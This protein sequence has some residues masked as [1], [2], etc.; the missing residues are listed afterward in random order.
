MKT[1]ILFLAAASAFA[2]T[3]LYLSYGGAGSSLRITG[4]TNATPIVCSTPAVHGFSTGNKVY[5][6]G[7]RGNRAAN[8]PSGSYYTVT[9]SPGS[10]TFSLQNP[11]SSPVAGTGAYDGNGFVTLV[12]ATTLVAHPRGLLDGPGGTITTRALDPD[13]TG[14]LKAPSAVTGFV[15]WD[16]ISTYNSS[17][18]ASPLSAASLAAVDTTEPMLPIGLAWYSNQQDTARR[19]AVLAW[20]NNIGSVVDARN[21]TECFFACCDETKVGCGVDDPEQDWRWFFRLG[22]M[23]TYNFTRSLM[24]TPERQAFADKMLNGVGGEAKVNRLTFGGTSRVTASG[25]ALTCVSGACNFTSIASPTNRKIYIRTTGGVYG[26]WNKIASV[27]DDN[28]IVLVSAVPSSVSAESNIPWAYVKDWDNTMYGDM[29]MSSH[30]AY[31]PTFLTHEAYSK[32]VGAIDAS[33]TTFS[34]QNCGNFPLAEVARDYYTKMNSEWMKLTDCT[35]GSPG[36]ATVERGALFSTAATHATLQAMWGTA[37]PQF[38][39]SHQAVPSST[40]NPW[41]LDLEAPSQNLYWSK[42]Y[43]TIK[44]ACA[45]ADDDERAR[46]L[47]QDGWNYFYNFVYPDAKDRWTG[48][49]QGGFSYGQPRWVTWMSEIAF[50]GKY[51]F[52]PAIDITDGEWLKATGNYMPHL[53][54]PWSTSGSMIWGDSG[55]DP[56]MFARFFRYLMIQ[57]RLFDAATE[58]SQGMFWFRE[59]FDKWTSA[60]MKGPADFQLMAPAYLYIPAD[61]TC[62]SAGCVDHRTTANL[63]RF[64]TT[65]DFDFT[66]YPTSFGFVSS[67]SDWTTAPLSWLTMFA[68]GNPNDHTGTQAPGTYKI[69]VAGQFL[70]ANGPNTLDNGYGANRPEGLIVIANVAGTTNVG[71][72]TVTGPADAI[73]DLA[74]TGNYIVTCTA[75]AA[76]GGTFSVAAPNGVVLG[77]AT[78]GV[79]F[80]AP[81]YYGPLKF[82]INDGSIDWAVGDKKMVQVLGM[83]QRFSRNS[84]P[85]INKAG[86][87][88]FTHGVA[89]PEQN[90]N[91]LGYFGNFVKVDQTKADSGYAFWRV[92]LDNSYQTS[93]A[94]TRAR[95]HFAH[96]T[97]TEAYTIVYDELATSSAKPKE[98]SAFCYT[99]DGI[100]TYSKSGN[101]LNCTRSAS[102]LQT[103][104]LLPTDTSKITQTGGQVMSSYPITYSSSSSSQRPNGVLR[105]WT[106]VN[107]V[108]WPIR[109]RIDDDGPGGGSTFVT[110]TWGLVGVDTGRQWYFNPGTAV[111]TQCD[112][113]TANTCPGAQEAA[114]PTNSYVS[115]DINTDRSAGWTI[116]DGSTLNSEF[117][118]VHCAFAGTTGD[119]PPTSTLTT[120]SSNSR[121]V[122]INHAARPRVF[123][124]DNDS[125]A[126]NVSVTF[127]LSGLSAAADAL[128]SGL[129][130]GTW[131]ILKDAVEIYGDVVVGADGTAHIP[132]AGGHG[133]GAY[134]F[135]KTGETVAIDI[136]TASPLPDGTVGTPYSET[137]TAS[138]GTGPYTW[139]RIGG[140]SFPSGLS[141]SA[142]GELTGTPDTA[143]QASVQVQA[144]DVTP[145]CTNKFLSITIQAAGTPLAWSTP[146]TF[147]D[148]Q[149]G[150]VYTTQTLVCTGG[151][152]PY[153][154]TLLSGT[155][156]GGLTQSGTGGNTVSGTLDS[157]SNGNYSP[158]FRCTDS[159]EPPA[160]ADRTFTF[161]I[162]PAASNELTLTSPT[163]PIVCVSESFCSAQWTATGGTSPLTWSIPSGTLPT[164]MAQQLDGSINGTPSIDGPDQDFP[165][166]VRVTGAT[167]GT[168]EDESDV[169]FSITRTSFSGGCT[170][171]SRA[172]DVG[173]TFRIRCSSLDAN[174]PV[175]VAVKSGDTVID[176]VTLT[177]GGAV[178]EGGLNGLTAA[179]SY[180]IDW[181]YLSQFRRDIVAT[182]ST[183]GGTANPKL[184][185]HPPQAGISRVRAK[186]GL[187]SVA[188]N[189]TSSQACSTGCA[190]TLPSLT[191]GSVYLYQVEWL[192]GSDVPVGPALAEAKLLIE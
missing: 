116:N 77:N 60:T 113:G 155:L 186:Y 62:P 161:D 7:V 150:T 31:L 129:D 57:Y 135:V 61:H 58:V 52:S 168:D 185:R 23:E 33:Q 181:N 8:T 98:R 178:R 100:V 167:G 131:D 5:I 158:A 166:R 188:E 170:F 27:T 132:A 45:L 41:E 103:K 26:H 85:D 39:G 46:K 74:V 86:T 34:V 187:A 126:A 138:G 96:L 101:T 47:C 56:S 95:R 180:N 146:T 9:T 175:T 152:S 24:S 83:D 2:Q 106:L 172:G 16:A 121:G 139:S 140:D 160:T 169:V 49:T 69:A 130:P 84:F 190:I 66:A 42:V 134:T 88:T 165:I 184:F 99:D 35:A 53:N 108:A 12:R 25:T 92:N 128:V 125:T 142:A 30:H 71:N 173:M 75:A 10:T 55:V 176:T 120:I 28:N 156:P 36:T 133:N 15:P 191:R 127:T 192:D 89:L 50:V 105:T 122:L 107:N 119:C 115:F 136:T 174:I 48:V 112:N 163:S 13:G 124:A 179:T 1:A 51:H 147:P 144:C 104:V 67:R 153:T 183:I 20:M 38:G 171:T 64:F 97:G 102:R 117:L 81:L 114:P 159:A 32:N 111:V 164:G 70:Y 93:A 11:D 91:S 14:P 63:T 141:F 6:F 65:D 110:K 29:W 148:A 76:D 151:T 162:T 44:A 143:T 154:Y 109:V 182:Q 118:L 59:I 19:D 137:F 17:Y 73:G 78:V 94:V 177:G 189:T 149:A 80:N 68:L 40:S 79:E 4:C 82:T 145:V 21:T 3:T 37:M 123:I 87:T 72:G 43:G 54:L 22:A 18:V 157:D 90:K